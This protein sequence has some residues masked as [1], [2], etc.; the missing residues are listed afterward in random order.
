MFESL[1][2]IL[3]VIITW[4]NWSRY[5]VQKQIQ[6]SLNEVAEGKPVR[7]LVS[8]SHYLKYFKLP[9]YIRNNELI[10]IEYNGKKINIVEDDEETVLYMSEEKED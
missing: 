7:S 6:K 5:Y 1:A 4:L 9:P 2:A 8:F 10:I 3:L